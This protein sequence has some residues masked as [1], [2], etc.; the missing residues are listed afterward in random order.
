[1][2]RI[3]TIA[4]SIGMLP[5]TKRADHDAWRKARR[6]P[7]PAVPP[8]P[9]RERTVAQGQ[10]AKGKIVYANA[11]ASLG[12]TSRVQESVRMKCILL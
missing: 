7:R 6:V 5:F 8:S 4:Q 9:P 12:A 10:L 11:V 3:A 1:M 2:T